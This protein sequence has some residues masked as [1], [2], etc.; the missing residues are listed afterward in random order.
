MD[1]ALL[2]IGEEAIDTETGS[3]VWWDG[4]GWSYEKPRPACP[5]P[6]MAQSRPEHL[7]LSYAQQRLWFLDQVGGTTAEYN[8]PEAMQLRGKLNVD[9]LTRAI[10]TI[11]ERHEALRTYFSAVDG[12]PVQIIQETLRI[13]VPVQDLQLLD[14]AQRQ[15]AIETAMRLEWQEPFDLQRGPLLRVKALRLGER[16]HII[17]WT[18]H[19]IV[20]DGWSVGVLS[21]ELVA[22]YAAFAEGR[23]DPLPL[24]RVQYADFALWQRAAMQNGELAEGL[25]YWK[26][27]LRGIPERLAL[28]TD[29]PRPAVQSFIADAVHAVIPPEQL[30]STMRLTQDSHA[31]LYMALLAA[32]ALLFARYSGQ[33]DIVIGSPIANR[34][35]ADL[36]QLIGFF[37]NSLVL[38]V[39]V[40]HDL[41]FRELL[42]AV[43]DTTLD[44]YQHQGVPFEQL[45]AEL[46]PE[47][48]LSS[49]PLFQVAFALQNAPSGTTSLKDLEI[50]RVYSDELRVRFD[51]EIHSVESNRGLEIVWV[52]NRDLFDRWRIEQMAGHFVNLLRDVVIRPGVP[53]HRL[54]MLNAVERGTLLDEFSCR[55]HPLPPATLS[56]L[57]EAQVARAPDALAIVS[58]VGSV[59]YGELNARANQLAHYLVS[60]GVVPESCVGVAMD[61][62]IEMWMAVLGI[63]KAGAAYLPLDP[64][65]PEARIAHMLVDAA[66][67]LVLNRDALSAAR[68]DDFPTYDPNVARSA[69]N[70]AYVIYTSGS[71]G[72]PKGVVVTHQGIASLSHDQ[73]ERLGVTP[74]SRI[75]QFAS[76]NFDASL[77]EAVMALS[78]GAALVL[79]QDDERTGSLLGE[80]LVRQRVTHAT[81]PPTILA[82]VDRADIPLETLIV[83]GE[84]C[85]P[86]LV[87]RWSRGR[88]FINAYGPTETT[89]CASMSVPLFG[90]Q[91][92]PI[93]TA[94][95]NTRL[96]VLDPALQPVPIGVNGELYVAGES[97]ARGYLGQAALTA[98]RF[99]A[100]PFSPE[101]GMRMYRTGDLVRWRID[102]PLEFIG[103][104]DTQV[105]LRGYRIELGEIE[106]ALRQH[107]RVRDAMV[108][109]HGA[110]EQQQLL[111][112]V[113][114]R[115][116]AETAPE[117]QASHI[118][119]W[120][121]L[122][123]ST[124]AAPS[125]E[126]AS[127]FNILGWNSSYTG[128]PIAA[129][130]MRLWVEETV[131][132]LHAFQPRNVL[133]IGCGTGLLLTRVAPRC[134]S[135][136][137]IDLSASALAQLELLRKTRCDLDHVMLRQSSADQLSFVSDDA[138]DLV[139]LN[140]VAQYFP[141]M[142]YLLGVLAEAVR[143]T[144]PGGHIFIGDI[145]S[146][147]LLDAFYL[148]VEL[149]KSQDSMSLS[150]LQHHLA[151]ARQNEKELIVDPALF[152]ELARRWDDVGR[153]DVSLKAGS[154]DNE[155]NR[156]R[157]DVTLRI[158]GKEAIAAPALWID[159]DEQGLWRQRVQEFDGSIGVRSVRDARVAAAVEAAR[160]LHNPDIAN[161]GQLRS[162]VGRPVGEDPDAVMRFAQRLG[163]P[164]AW[165]RF[166]AQGSYDCV[167]RPQWTRHE[168]AA[169]A[170]RF[171]YGRY[172]NEPVRRAADLELS[173]ALPE[174]LRE[175]LPDFMVP[176][177]IMVLSAW[178]LTPAG[179]IDRRALPVPQRA[180]RVGAGFVAPRSETARLLA[181][182]WKSVLGLDLVGEE[183]DFFAIGGHSL[184]AAQLMSRV[185][186][187]FNVEIPI[188]IVFDTPKLGQLANAIDEA[189][190]GSGAP[191]PPL[192]PMER[193][194][195]LTVSYAQ[196]GLWFIDKLQGSSPEYNMPGAWRL[197]GH[198][199]VDALE[200]AINTIIERH[201]N[202]RVHFVEVEGEPFQVIEAKMHIDLPVERAHYEDVRLLLQQQADEPFDLSQGPLVRARLM[203]L[204]DDD[205]VLLWTCHHIVSDAWSMGVLNREFAVL[206]AAFRDG[207][208][209]PL[210]PLAVQYADFALW[211]RGWLDSDA[212]RRG[213]DY[214]KTQLTGIPDRLQ[215]PTDRP[216]PAA[217][218]FVAD[219]C[220]V[221]MP[222]RCLE[223]LKHLGLSNQATLYMTLLA[224][225]A[226]LMKRYTGQRD[227]V[228]GSPIANRH[229]K[230]LE[231][232]IGFFVNSLV[233][234][235]GVRQDATFR[236][237]LRDVRRV[238]LEAYQHQEIP[239]ERLVEELSVERRFDLTPIFQVVFALQN[240]PAGHQS[241][242]GLQI[243]SIVGDEP[244]VRFDLEVHA[245][246][247]DGGLEFSWVYNRD[248][249]DSWRIEQMA[250][251]YLTL[252][253]S[254]LA[255]P[256]V[257]LHRVDVLDASERHYLIIESNVQAQFADETTLPERFE[258]QA[259]RTP[260][261]VAVIFENESITYAE[262]NAR[263]NQLAHRLLRQG[264]R[265]ESLV[266]I[267]LERSIE[268][269][270]A[271]LGV[272]KAGAA[273]LPL[274]P[275]S[276]E[277]RLSAMIAD[278]APAFVIRPETFE[279]LSD[280]PANDPRRGILLPDHPAYVIY[281]SGST[282]APKG[283]LVTHRNIT[284][285]FDATNS[286]YSFGPDDVWTMCHSVAFDFSVW[287]LLGA[288]L[289]G[290]RV[291]VVSR[292][293]TQ[294]PVDLLALLVARQVTVLNQTPSAFYQLM[295]ADGDRPDLGDRLQLRCVIFGGEAL[296]PARLE[297][298]YRRHA[299]DAPFLFNM[300][301]ITETTVHV[302]SVLL[303]RELALTAGG[304]VIGANLADLRIYVLDAGLEPVP[305]G[306]TGELYVAGAGLARGYLNRP[307]LSAERFVADPYGVL[308]SRMYR[309]GDLA[310]RRVGGALEFLG[311]ADQQVKIRGFRIELGEIEAALAQHPA[312]AQ[313]A[314]IARDLGSGDKQLVGYVV[315]GLGRGTVEPL[316]LANELRD[317]LLD[318]LPEYMVPAN[319]ML[320]QALPLNVNGKLDRRVLPIPGRPTEGYRAPRT[321]E[322]EILCG[323]FADV[324]KLNR[325]G[326]DDDF[327]SLGGHS[328]LAT[329]V[330]SRV[331]ST[332]NVELA[333][334]SL[335]ESTTIAE[336]APRLRHRAH[337][338]EPLRVQDRPE[339][340]PLS[341]A[342]QRLWF[343][344][345]IE[346]ANPSYNI[347]LALRLEGNLDV[348]GLELALHDVVE[349]H[350]SLRTIFPEDNGVPRQQVLR[351]E[352]A[353]VRVIRDGTSL[354]EAAR[355]AFKLRE[356]IPLR[357]WLFTPTKDC[358][359]LMLVVH[360]IAA[361]GWSLGPLARDL[362]VA[363]AARIR[364]EAP[365]WRPLPVQYA[366]YAI[367][368]RNWLTDAMP[369]Q[370]AFWRKALA[371]L[372]V[373]LRLPVDHPRPPVT[374][375]RGS[376]VQLHIDR[377][378]HLRLHELALANGA[379]LFMVIQAA[380]A[381]LLS[382]IGAGDDIPIGT[383]IAGRG[384]SATEELIGL[385]A[386][387]LVL[388]TDVSGNPSFNELVRRVR[389]FAL[390]AFEHQDLPFEQ[391]V[392]ALKPER[393]LGRNPLFQVMLLVEQ[394]GHD[395]FTLPG[396]SVSGEPIS[397]DI[398]RFDLTL[399]LSE[400]LG[401]GGE[402]LGIDA[403][404][405]YNLD[406]F[407]RATVES[408]AQRFVR[409]IEAVVEDPDVPLHRIG[410][411]GADERHALLCGAAGYQSAS[412][413]H[414]SVLEL[415][416]AQVRCAPNATALVF[417]NERLTYAD[418]SDRANSLAHHLIAQG[419]GPGSLVGIELDRS[420]EMVVAMFGV[421]M[422]GA[423]YVPLD[424][425]YPRAR[426]ADMLAD[427]APSL[428]VT[429]DLVWETTG[430]G[431]P[432]AHRP[433]FADPAYVI[434]T[435]GSTGRPKGV[436]IPHGAL[437]TFIDA[438]KA[439][440]P[441]APGER[442]L[443]VTTIGFDISILEIL[444][445]LCRGAEVWIA[446]RDT[447]RDPVRLAKLIRAGKIT[448]LQVTP[449][450][451]SMLAEQDLQ[452]LNNLRIYIGGEAL[453]RDL[454]LVLRECGAEV[455][456]L[457]GP[458]EATIWASVHN[459]GD[460][461]LMS[462]ASSVV[463]IGR[464]L[465]N[466]RMY[467]LDAALEPVPNGVVGELYIAG[468]ALALGYLNRL[469]QTA[470]RF[471]A[472]PHGMAGMRMYR[473][474]DLAS[475]RNDDTLEFHGRGDAQ[476]KIRGF[477]VE[478]GEIEV[479][480][481]RHETVA[482]ATVVARD[483]GLVAYVVPR[484]GLSINVDA[485]RLA[486]AERLPDH[487]VPMVFVNLEQMPLLPNGKLDRGG[488]PEP[489]WT[490]S[491]YREP[492]TTNEA[493]LRDIFAD[494]LALERV[495]VDDN[496]FAIG[497]HSLLATR[498]VSRIWDVF[499]VELPLKAVF[500]NPTAAGIAEVLSEIE[501]L[502]RQLDQMSPEQLEAMLRHEQEN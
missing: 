316:R 411:L 90:L 400:H 214:W 58:A 97:L 244:G 141:D 45:V 303:N 252:L 424:P 41:T 200:R 342:Q 276:P 277:A 189:R 209:N 459:V 140:S 259:A 159:W 103:R 385:F 471:V 231:E 413:L 153:A 46:L 370:V 133:E 146:L 229:E 178:P 355:V 181:G 255:A 152:A 248:L 455:R 44:A 406:L 64:T 131:A 427:A 331:R 127:D 60:K 335:F 283:V 302:S 99:V 390:E 246:E 262:L 371:G 282:G 106:E 19:H 173:H 352:D 6:L 186:D 116:D 225:F 322:E 56:E 501:Q 347:P 434:Y 295:Q 332:L 218:T 393:A 375:Y 86:E 121:Q 80:L 38:R 463:S 102:G 480:L 25:A 199:D 334:R 205:H 409:L 233:M 437:S 478:P 12:E 37:V 17:L 285:L 415:F 23:E 113:I 263:S 467:V 318:R 249:F 497:G 490:T 387:T 367:W 324:L 470:E 357:A 267:L 432:T 481:T 151:Q 465:T 329:R 477:R 449:T 167:F 494:V 474:G 120:Q 254:A 160:L 339:P 8:M 464:P 304:S 345:R 193:P 273:Y 16:D 96:Y 192:R 208:V 172:G 105:K 482:Q 122:Y 70:S 447:V 448:S 429:R 444:V 388:R 241:V 330:V 139:I 217:R 258:A 325:I 433:S 438:I 215:L 251:H 247:R 242:K 256:D 154:Y 53:L 313:A 168:A 226:L 395:E 374:S 498:L 238:T 391:V 457:Y 31:T 34:E 442:H 443:A 148:S 291:V 14:N 363:Y 351:S 55:P 266:G 366:D 18:S 191:K 309:T 358:H 328:L 270:V 399:G 384:E 81:L 338:R 155:L 312:V 135:Y 57:F 290:G 274:D 100:N 112:Y 473:T 67:T 75:L 161:V 128:G 185:R 430:P 491:A 435:S 207:G 286:Y 483:R 117:A 29:R 1:R 440:V 353:C 32:L 88:C 147:P 486:L 383:P 446:D 175:T 346:G 144:K 500:E 66:P 165:Q 216:R 284:R 451:M 488:L 380:F 63:M 364:G 410:I 71:T 299:E 319:I 62:S 111:G 373:E 114:S 134:E 158:G 317:H 412:A 22:L 279:A 278:A 36:E 436:V 479:L 104:V 230:Q 280:E 372:P 323:I 109:V 98:D 82:T 369:R 423:G 92:P 77:W 7:P 356:E 65:Y 176:S 420:L 130:E 300:Y 125:P 297:P 39:Q 362:T 68:L 327:F 43:R 51:L 425:D 301:G 368:Q 349:R 42:A 416:D 404:L 76:L 149:F 85:P 72:V 73:V 170:L 210:Q 49:T 118:G 348:N 11:V 469:A 359:I 314:V 341:Y 83:A 89:V 445:P 219:V 307:G 235:V 54:A 213:L 27:H 94:V 237:L 35:E 95:S 485:L 333:I 257:A 428:V 33:D 142:T 396:L 74:S 150:G 136:I 296:E 232:L 2:V 87:D 405:E 250:R 260:S 69:T 220:N 489:L 5:A 182:V 453:S 202:L 156:F 212:I 145:R 376:V 321:P 502:E 315:P 253:E 26:G 414:P 197:R 188:R 403:G 177:A 340:I 292:M 269:V 499:E 378:S 288:L 439:H 298:W 239:F 310:R 228:L 47:R 431:Y 211:Q 224:A 194:A 119:Y 268:M 101:P 419:V 24:L 169:N 461:D 201:E 344:Y 460:M 305:L 361:D 450:H 203:R 294:S 408:I 293:V 240:A 223:A 402:Q 93:G 236:D 129:A 265:A 475:W 468:S 343:L 15:E 21:R 311:R 107:D 40:R 166:T 138:V 196:R 320:L 3:P 180:D 198:L 326:I 61:R 389:G 306:V 195:L 143:V 365:A 493:M 227:I 417:G 492:R 124:H 466:Y 115:D 452:C 234:R 472:D 30:S 91:N 28:P 418:L 281:T 126:L 441:F 289:Y 495:G 271:I 394:M 78:N 132:R 50:A 360:H 84:G 108:V 10:N 164:Y 137:G 422:A 13:A 397:G 187:V 183:D 245:S 421:L 275:D 381:A 487:M 20:S 222:P 407:E 264:V 4:K 386:N 287:E 171:D 221:T 190:R 243:E 261:A 110:G 462:S 9:A 454:A 52:Y 398:A 496:F 336:L 354:A 79:P 272:V 162:A 484:L 379:T 382:K 392:D 157:Y 48:D 337:L 204:G 59:K 206:Y 179:K 426:L 458:T 184:M 401:A 476:L 123:D 456:N 377:A 350:E 174:A 163:I 308:G